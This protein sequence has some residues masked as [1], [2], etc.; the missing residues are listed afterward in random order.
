MDR[1]QSL[2]ELV[3]AA[4][5]PIGAATVA[6]A[7]TFPGRRH[8]AFSVMLRDAAGRVLL[9]QRAE[10]KT[11]FALRWS[12][13]CCGHPGPGEDLAGAAGRRLHEE[14]GLAGPA[15]TEIGVYP[16]RATDQAT[17]RVE[18]EYDHVLVGDWDGIQPRPDPAEIADW[19]WVPMAQ[20]RMDLDRHKD[21]YTPWLAGVL[22]IVI[23]SV[24]INLAQ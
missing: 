24:P 8:R 16:Y 2:V 9:Q 21:T 11:R 15:L 20:L 12:N 4:G 5:H 23:A 14:L 3:D 19:R 22:S 1:E 13:T 18:D 7:H 6:A 17:G 10:A